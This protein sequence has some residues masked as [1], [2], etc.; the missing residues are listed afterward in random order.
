MNFQKYIFLLFYYIANISYYLSKEIEDKNE[1]M[2]DNNIYCDGNDG[3]CKEKEIRIIIKYT[4]RSNLIINHFNQL[5]ETIEA[6]NRNIVII[7]EDY[8]LEGTRKKIS[9]TI[10]ALQLILSGTVTCSDSV[11][12]LTRNY[13][14]RSFFDWTYKNKIIK[15][16][17]IFLVGNFINSII[18]NIQPFEIFYDGNLIWSGIKHNGKLIRPKELIKIIHKKILN[19]K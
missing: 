2:N 5:K 1:N 14:P 9:Y 8:K 11:I 12:Y 4:K 16:V 10:V 19:N 13:I 15:V 18:N 6:E 7:G 3:N 17:F